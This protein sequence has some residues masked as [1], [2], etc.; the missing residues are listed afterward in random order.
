MKTKSSSAK[1]VQ[2]FYTAKEA[3]EIAKCSVQTIM[4]FIRS[5]ELMALQPTGPRGTILIPQGNLANWLTSRAYGA[6]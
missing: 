6:K 5:G 3:S 2:G 1:V 4:R